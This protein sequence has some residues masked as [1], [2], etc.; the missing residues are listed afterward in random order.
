LYWIK[1]LSSIPRHDNIYI[2]KH[3]NLSGWGWCAVGIEYVAIVS[4]RHDRP[5]DMLSC[6]NSLFFFA[7][8][9]NRPAYLLN[10]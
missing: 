10:V 9:S 7:L 1:K 8:K 4:G 3:D 5:L 6:Y 2:R